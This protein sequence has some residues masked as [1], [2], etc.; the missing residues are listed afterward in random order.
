M[1]GKLHRCNYA[2]TNHGGLCL[3]SK[4]GFL[5]IITNNSESAN[6]VSKELEWTAHITFNNNVTLISKIGR[7][8]NIGLMGIDG[9]QA[10]KIRERLGGLLFDKVTIRD[11]PTRLSYAQ[12]NVINYIESLRRPNND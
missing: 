2:A 7:W 8:A 1:R 4:L 6:N 12:Q 5:H 9:E 11:V 3:R 10:T